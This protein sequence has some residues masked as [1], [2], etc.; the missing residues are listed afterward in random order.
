MTFKVIR[1]QGQGQEMTSVP[2]RDYLYFNTTTIK[3]T[4]YQRFG[5][6]WVWWAIVVGAPSIFIN[7][8]P[9]CSTS[10]EFIRFWQQYYIN[11]TSVVML[12][13]AIASS[14]LYVKLLQ[15]IHLFLVQTRAVQQARWTCKSDFPAAHQ[16]VI[17]S[18]E[19]AE[20]RLKFFNSILRVTAI[21]VM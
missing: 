7:G 10:T 11:C 14:L 15:S 3:Y 2:C 1:G 19:K 17:P 6:T 18:R 8:G 9:S 4:V 21:C 20:D 16:H 13:S 12:Q 5:F